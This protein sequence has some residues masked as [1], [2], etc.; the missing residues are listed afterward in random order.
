MSQ[1][2]NLFALSASAV[3]EVAQDTINAGIPSIVDGAAIAYTNITVDGKQLGTNGIAWKMYQDGT[4]AN[5]TPQTGRPMYHFSV[6][7]QKYP[8]EILANGAVLDPNDVASNAIFCVG[9]YIDFSLASSP[10]YSSATFSWTLPGIYKNAETNAGTYCSTDPYVD[11]NLLTDSTTT[12]WWVSGGQPET[13]TVNLDATF[14][15][16]NGQ[17][18]TMTPSGQFN[19]WRPTSTVTA[20]TGIVEIGYN[21]WNPLPQFAL[22]YGNNLI[23]AG[24]NLPGIYMSCSVQVLASFSGGSNWVQVVASAY[25]SAETNDDSGFWYGENPSHVL[26]HNGDPDNHG[27]NYLG[28]YYKL[29]SPNTGPN[30]HDSPTTF[31][32]YSAND[33]FNTW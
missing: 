29:D 11:T 6:G 14:N 28:T 25:R 13:Y 5:V 9:Q 20:Q 3:E 10:P 23:A 24:L 4:T 1:Q 19:M 27:A 26:D 22:H 2:K 16:A 18:V 32:V 31:K 8:M 12:A 30:T 7:Q 21:Y 33:E 17:S 15:F